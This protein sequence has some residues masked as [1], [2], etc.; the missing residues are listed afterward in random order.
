MNKPP[1]RLLAILVAAAATA[2]VAA[3]ACAPASPD[4]QEDLRA[5][6]ALNQHDVDAVLS[7]DFD[8]LISQWTDDFVVITGGAIVRGRDANAALTEGARATAHLLEPVEHHLDFEE[9]IVAGDYAFQW[10]T[11]RSSSRAIETGEVYSSSGKLLR[12]LQRQ[13]DG[14]W[15][16]HRTMTVPDASND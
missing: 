1:R 14:S 12:I 10:G 4:L 15:K 8:A 3:A 5:I 7:G 9:T 2:A 6:E 11:V 16:M 13:P